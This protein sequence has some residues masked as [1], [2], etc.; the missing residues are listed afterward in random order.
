MWAHNGWTCTDHPQWTLNGDKLE[1]QTAEKDEGHLWFI[2]SIYGGGGETFKKPTKKHTASDR[3]DQIQTHMLR[4]GEPRASCQSA[5]SDG[6][7][8]MEAGTTARI[9]WMFAALSAV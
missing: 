6:L 9:F 4:S 1:W 8:E 2:Y 3:V 5:E 7:R